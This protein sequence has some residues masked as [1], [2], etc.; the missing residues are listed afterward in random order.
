MAQ[1]F[2][3][4]PVFAT[5]ISI[6]I[7][8]VGLVAYSSLPSA[9]YP[10]VAP[11]TIVVTASYPGA[12]PEVVAKT[13]AAPI[14]QEINGVEDMLY[15]ES[16]STA[17]GSMTLTI[18]F[19]LGTDLNTAQ[20]LVQNRV[21]IA[22]P[23]LP[24]VVRQIGV[25]VSKRS[26]DLL[27]VIHMVS[28]DDTYDQLYISNYALLQ[29]RDA[30]AR[31]DGVGDVRLFGSR[32]Y[33]MRVWL[34]PER[35]SALNITAS[36]VVNA[37]RA[38]N[39][40]VAAGVVGQSP[41]PSGVAFQLPVNTTGRLTEPDEFRRI[42]VRT[43]NEGQ[44]V[45]VGDVAD[46]ELGSYD[47]GVNSYLS[48][49]PAVAV[50]IFQRPGSNALVTS[51]AVQ[52][53]MKKLGQNFPPGLEYRI[54]Y[55]PTE[56][57]AES[58]EAVYHTLYEAAFLV[59]LVI[60]VFLQNWR[61]SLIPLLAI[62]VSLIG[63]FAI[64]ALLGISLNNLSLFG[65]VLAI[66][67]VVDDAIVVVENIER[68]VREGKRPLEATREAMKEVSGALVA[69]GLVLVSVFIPTTFLGGI[70][71]QFYQ[72]FG[73]TVAVSTMISVLVSLTLSPALSAKLIQDHH[74]KPDVLTR[75]WNFLFGWFFRLFN[76]FFDALS[77]VYAS[78]VRGLLRLWPVSLV[79]YG[80]LLGLTW[81]LF[82]ITPT[83]FV[84]AQDQGY[85]II[86]V[87]MPPGAS[88]ERTDKVVKEVTRICLEHPGIDE[89]V[90]F[91]GWSGA[92]RS[93]AS[94]A[95][96]LFPVLA[97]FEERTSPE[98]SS[99]A[100]I[101]DLR[102]QLGAIRDGQVFV[103]PPPPVRGVGSAGG[104]KF[105]VQD[106]RDAGSKALEQEAQK[107]AMAA[108]GVPGLVG[109]FSPYTAST[110]QLFADIDRTKAQ[111]LDVPL[112]NIFE[113]MQY[114]LSSSYVNDFNLYGRVYRVTAQAKQGLRDDPEDLRL[115]KTRSRTGAAVPLS[116]VMEL[117]TVTEPDRIVRYNL[118][119]SADVSG[120]TIPGF[121][122]GQSI[123]AIEKLAAEN[124]PQGM[125]IAWTDLAYQQKLAGNA[126]LFIFILSVLFVYLQL[127][128]QYESWSL[129]F[130]VIL[131]VP[132][133]LLFAILGVMIRGMDNN[134]MTQIGLVVLVALACKNAILI[135]EFAKQQQDA[136]L[137][138]FD[139]A[140]EAARLRLRPI[141]MTAFAFILG[142]LPL[143]FASGPGAEMRQA[144][145]TA[146]FA[147]MLGVTIFGLFL[148]PVFYYVIRWMVEGKPKEEPPAQPQSQPEETHAMPS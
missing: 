66:G 102:Q 75:I 36:E 111:M 108:N 90:A 52:E 48:G 42:V 20:V 106:R 11:P 69:M 141:L 93:N 39:V 78:M 33:S 85:I 116:S 89:T 142:V 81:F 114:Y 100:I 26:P 80:G 148:T 38:Q 122:S 82:T 126:G 53:E 44:L 107:L 12:T 88:L 133:C 43:G 119:P 110:P 29:V 28:P 3:T 101:A 128:A 58:V 118:Y 97:P 47:Y 72:Q 46:V 1:Y 74:E 77:N 143:V 17:E 54:V 124:L 41:T 55:N 103:I 76:K 135:V 113:T 87:Q 2:I 32:E 62:P 21:A 121:S 145:G 117:R 94:N 79:V 92:T 10:E 34:D 83:G 129:P 140:V 68:L 16:Q 123:E 49:E 120:D 37:L 147:G 14:E 67:I 146:V 98:L 61:V 95:A 57:I 63:T 104:Y 7:T 73:I 109:V 19:E 6:L 35:L 15:M 59:V 134:I 64:M 51:D 23:R 86:A 13:V 65:L 91:V 5:V 144:L 30:L 112:G 137:N 139:A 127:C 125:E 96:G 70:S 22:E 25:T 31:V 8:L 84:P 136:G 132:M 105:Y 50:V 40:Q 71:G 56:F 138:R 4:R 130:A 115:L 99:D 45:R 60:M 24:E 9:Q 27:M 18:T 131:I